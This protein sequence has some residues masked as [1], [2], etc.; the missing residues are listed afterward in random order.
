MYCVLR[1]VYCVLC[2]CCLTC[3]QCTVYCADLAAELGKAVYVLLLIVL[4]HQSHADLRRVD[5]LR[6]EIQKRG[7]APLVTVAHKRD[8]DR[9]TVAGLPICQ[10]RKGVMLLCG[11][12]AVT[13]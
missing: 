12:I 4:L 10:F 13:I 9:A 11:S 1:T 2:V 8:E 3:A 7:G 6:K 5:G